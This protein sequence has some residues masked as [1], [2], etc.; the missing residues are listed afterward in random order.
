MTDALRQL[1]SVHVLTE[2]DALSATIA[3]FGRVAVVR[4]ARA[5]LDGARQVIRQ[6]GSAPSTTDLL[7]TIRGRLTRRPLLYSAVLNAT[8]VILHT[9]LGR[10]PLPPAAWEAMQQAAGYCDLELDLGTG[11]RASRLRGVEETLLAVTS[12]EAGMIVNNNAA[13]VLL[14]I[15]ALA[16]DKPTAISRGHLVEIGGGFRL[17]T[18]MEASGSPIL[19]VGTTNRTHLKDYVAAM[20]KGVGLVLS[21]HRSN[22]VMSGYVTEPT[23]AEILGAARDANVPVALDLGS[24]ALLETAEHGLP[25]ET[26]VHAA[27]AEGFDLV[28]FSGDKLLGGSQAG[29]IV[30]NKASVEACPETPPGPGPAMRQTATGR[31]GHDPGVVPAG[32]GRTAS[33]DLAVDRRRPHRPARPCHGVAR[34]FAHWRSRRCRGRGRRRLAARGNARGIRARPEYR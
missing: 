18:I 2:D 21:V 6:N 15:A 8:G 5:A 30:G 4:A 7:Q 29:F 32:R 22:F 19:E 20:Q 12:A 34:S 16:G 9:N 28:C 24:G 14:S 3:E 31:G 13:A 17:P 33:T 27:V 25:A 10:A 11:K 26:T 23:A 1:P